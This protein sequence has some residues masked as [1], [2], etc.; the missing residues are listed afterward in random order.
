MKPSKGFSLIEMAI[1]LFIMSILMT[2]AV[3]GFVAMVK[4]NEFGNLRNIMESSKGEVLLNTAKTKVCAA[5]CAYTVTLPV[6]SYVDTWGSPVVFKLIGPALLDK[7]STNV[8]LVQILSLGPDHAL[9]GA[10][11]VEIVMYT[12]E[13]LF[14]LSRSGL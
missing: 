5:D 1:V 13:L 6:A 14:L 12:A 8:P 4:A 10:D 11:D 9:G 3:S 7:T 2:G